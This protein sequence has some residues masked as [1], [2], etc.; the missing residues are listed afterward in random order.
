MKTLARA[1]NRVDTQDV[2]GMCWRET[3]VERPCDI[4]I[5]IEVGK[6]QFN[7][8]PRHCDSPWRVA[9]RDTTRLPI[10]TRTFSRNQLSTERSRRLAQ[11]R[12]G[13]YSFPYFPSLSLF[14][15]ANNLSNFFHLHRV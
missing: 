7:Y 3:S 6:S 11:A 1:L 15:S 13:D 4:L 5:H 8:A 12:R 10:V 9:R 14:F 2:T